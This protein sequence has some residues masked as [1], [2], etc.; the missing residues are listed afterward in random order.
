M[1]FEIFKINQD[2]NSSRFN[3]DTSECGPEYEPYKQG[4]G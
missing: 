2:S 4:Y 1:K 3:Q